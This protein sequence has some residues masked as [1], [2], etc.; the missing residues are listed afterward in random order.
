MKVAITQLDAHKL[1]ADWQRLKD[2]ISAQEPQLLLLPEMCFAP[3]F[4]ADERPDGDSWQAA[5]NAHEIWLGRLPE[6]GVDIIIGTA[7]RNIGS[8]R[9]NWAYVWTG[10]AGLSWARGK[11]Y[12]PND[13]GFWEANWYRRAPIDFPLISIGR[14]RIGIMICTELWF[15]RHAREY[16]KL[17]AHLL[18][19][20][21]STPKHTNAKWLAGG[22]AAAVISGAYCLS[23]NH[24]GA[25]HDQ[26]L[27]GMGWLCDPE[28][29]VLATSSDEAPFVTLEIDLANAEAAKRSYPRYVDDG[30]VAP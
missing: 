1:E 4:C 22:Q 16:G 26:A 13:E 3:W 18:L 15:M 5:V 7:P 20:P 27:G 17:G 10:Q 9:Q 14:L 8:Q 21:R 28:G 25:I 11:T 30:P 29:N 24:A 12:L 19:I 23:S 6:L 2:H